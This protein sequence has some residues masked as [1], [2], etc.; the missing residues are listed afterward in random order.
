M[1]KEGTFEEMK[2]RISEL[3]KELAMRRR[4]EE[5]LRFS[6]KR[7]SSFMDRLPAAVFI[8]D[9]ESRYVYV[10]RFYE[11]VLG[12]KGVIGK[13]A[14]QVFPESLSRSMLLDDRKV[15]SGEL[16]IREEKI[17][18]A[19]GKE[20]VFE[21]HKFLMG[22][23]KGLPLIGGIALDITERKKAEERLRASEERFRSIVENSHDGIVIIDDNFCLEYANDEICKMMGYGPEELVGTDFRKFLDEESLGYTVERY[24][25]RQRDEEVPPRYEINFVRKNGEEIR[26]E[27]S[28]SIVST[29]MGERRTIAQLLDITER[30]K[31][32]EE[33]KKLE[34]QLRQAQKME[35]VGTLAGGVAHDF[36]NVLQAI[37]GYTQMLL[38]DR[39]EDDPVHAKLKR[40]ENSA[41]RASELTQ[42]LL[43]F[44]RKVESELR[45]LDL[46][47]EVR[48]VQELLEKTIPKM[49]DI[50]MYLQEDLWIVNA[51]P[52]QMEQVMM[53]LGV[54]ARDAM[55][56]GG[57]LV[58][59]T[60]N[61]VLDRQYCAAHLGAKPG[62]FVLLCISDTGIGMDKDAL[63]HIFEPF[64]TTKEVGKGTGLGLA[65]V[66]GIVKNHDGYIMCYSEPNKGTTFKIYL[67]VVESQSAK[68]KV[69][70]EEREL[71]GGGERIL[72]V[73]DEEPLRKMGKEILERFGYRVFTVRDGE[74]AVE[75]YREREGEIDLVILDLV[76]PGMGGKRCLEELLCLNDSLKI[77]IA[78]GYSVNGSTRDVV[79]AG[80]KGFIRKPYE[81]RQMLG[82]VREA[83]DSLPD[84]G[85]GENR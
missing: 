7:F 34:A 23:Q 13:T 14:D 33:K 51:D 11:D 25:K 6:E 81:L 18:D 30:K 77:V 22:G 4:V 73:D 45:P 76:M 16:R 79:D 55:P 62:K 47:S 42:Q 52:M 17:E 43:T 75:A 85:K 5:D 56:E 21:T 3:E 78:S 15:L 26:V 28:I 74:S 65:M 49:I 82:T 39:T 12:V 70:V 27:A 67:P 10:N 38:L 35:A 63:D 8:K 84:T 60:E 19:E 83:L 40:I 57:K 59:E 50:E 29:E 36:N 61:V 69:I 72:L 32:A 31:A 1:K 20:R 2:K 44:S 9:T 68:E 80:A 71:R 53:N 46:N 54:N 24:L 64:Y 37:L 66:Y 48:Q 41:H 58:F